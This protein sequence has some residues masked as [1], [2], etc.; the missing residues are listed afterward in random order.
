MRRRRLLLGAGVLALLGLVAVSALIR[1]Q[2]FWP[3]V[4]R[5]NYDRIQTGMTLDQVEF[6]LGG[7][8]GDYGAWGRS[9]HYVA[10]RVAQLDDKGQI[11]GWAYRWA[12]R[13]QVLTVY[14]DGGAG[15]V[16]RK[17]IELTFSPP[18]STKR[19]LPKSC[20]GC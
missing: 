1:L 17:E 10:P 2:P 15:R 20:P 7:P 5:A 11:T 18:P 19:G 14:F 9:G 12:G 13:P 6:L 8:P 3:E 4:S 16:V